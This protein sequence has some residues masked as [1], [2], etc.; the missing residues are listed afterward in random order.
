MIDLK[1][2]LKENELVRKR[3]MNAG[4]ISMRKDLAYDLFEIEGLATMLEG[5]DILYTPGLHEFFDYVARSDDRFSRIFLEDLYENF[6]FYMT[7]SHNVLT[8]FSDYRFDI[9]GKSGKEQYTDLGEDSLDILSEFLSS[10]DEKLYRM[11]ISMY[12][13]GRIGTSSMFDDIDSNLGIDGKCFW[14][15]SLRKTYVL[16]REE[17]N[18]VSSLSLLVHELGHSYE[19][20][21]LTDKNFE[22]RQGIYAT[23]LAE[24]S[25]TFLENA[26][27]E[28]LIENRINTKEALILKHR[29]LKLLFE[30]FLQ[31]YI[32]LGSP[33]VFD[34]GYFVNV[35]KESY[36][37]AMQK[38]KK[39]FG[40]DVNIK[41]IELN[42][43]SL[44]VYG[45]S[46]LV[47]LGLY[48][49]YKQDP[50]AFKRDFENILMSYGL[51]KDNSIYS[52]LG[53][54]DKDL[55]EATMLVPELKRDRR[56]L[57]F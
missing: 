43:N 36:E 15:N 49:P 7:Q 52:R 38:V 45:N 10:Y 9:F 35:S 5:R 55:S 53:V 1:S 6:E 33:N 16:G 25:S 40:F 32:A 31:A 12:E 37:R 14:I 29:F 4:S 18:D 54:T 46:M 19:F 39:D 13:S 47:A 44:L 8:R 22:Q 34:G 17:Y 3:L 20:Q 51:C 24:V 28:F 2:V 48:K 26:F 23:N 57:R 56:A 42:I 21:L 11:F 27:L 41:N 50:K 30:Q